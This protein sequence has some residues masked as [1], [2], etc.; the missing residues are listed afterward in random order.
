MSG[1]GPSWKDSWGASFG[2]VDQPGAWGLAW[3]NSWGNAWDRL[4]GQT[5]IHGDCHLSSL[6]IA[7]QGVG[8]G[9]KLTAVQGLWCLVQP[10]P[11]EPKCGLSPLAIALQGVGYGMRLMAV[12]GFSCV[13]QCLPDEKVPDSGGAG[14]PAKPKSKHDKAA[15]RFIEQL[16]EEDEILI[17]LIGAA[18]EQGLV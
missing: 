4:G 14:K 5:V 10:P 15:R 17:A 8:Y 16:R 1:W 3:G 9:Y 7:V 6:A 12:Q 18:W 11:V 13:C 2:Q